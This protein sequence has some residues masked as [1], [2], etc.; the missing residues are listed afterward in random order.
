MTTKQTPLESAK[1]FLTCTEELPLI[2]TA[3]VIEKVADPEGYYE[4][5]PQKTMEVINMAREWTAKYGDKK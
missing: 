2:I 4:A 5:K 1:T 3:E